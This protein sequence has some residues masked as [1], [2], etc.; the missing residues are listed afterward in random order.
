MGLFFIIFLCLR[1][2]VLAKSLKELDSG[3]HRND[4]SVYELHLRSGGQVMFF[5]FIAVC[6]CPLKR[7]N[8]LAWGAE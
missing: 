3:L 8:R 7:F 1:V 5:N 6:R 2:M 4:N